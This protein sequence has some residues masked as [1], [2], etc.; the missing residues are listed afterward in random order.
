MDNDNQLPLFG[1]KDDLPKIQTKLKKVITK[2]RIDEMNKLYKEG[3]FTLTVQRL[4]D[5]HEKLEALEKR[6]KNGK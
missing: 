2:E 4:E 6:I 3:K 5:M 1:F